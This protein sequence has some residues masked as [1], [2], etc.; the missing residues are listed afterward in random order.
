M[1]VEIRTGGRAISFL[2]IF[3]SNFRYSIFAVYRSNSLKG[4]GARFYFRIGFLMF[5]LSLKC[6]VINEKVFPIMRLCSV[7]PFPSKF[8]FLFKQCNK[9][10]WIQAQGLLSTIPT[11]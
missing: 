4:E 1:N 2:G 8:L 5:E 6:L 11:R 3:F 7:H 10:P 9:L